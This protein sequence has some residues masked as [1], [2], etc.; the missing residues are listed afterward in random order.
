MQSENSNIYYENNY[1]GEELYTIGSYFMRGLKG[2][3]KNNR[4]G[5]WYLIKALEYN[6]SKAQLII[7]DIYIRGLYNLPK[8]KEEGLKYLILSANQKN[9]Y[10]QNILGEI[11][12]KGLYGVDKNEKLGI[13]Y[14]HEGLKDIVIEALLKLKN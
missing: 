6:N 4:L 14:K 1:I 2:L 11:Y 7:G 13:T 10:A 8:N 12:L 3:P 9:I 5:I